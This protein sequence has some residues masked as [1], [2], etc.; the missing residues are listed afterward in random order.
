MHR[1]IETYIFHLS[2]PYEDIPIRSG[3]KLHSEDDVIS[4]AAAAAI[5]DIAVA[6]APTDRV[7]A[8]STSAYEPVDANL[9]PC[10]TCSRTF[11]RPALERHVKICEKV[12]TKKRNVFDPVKQRIEVRER[13]CVN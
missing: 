10:P 13:N 2:S 6:L 7:L 9:L 5:P 12:S 11:L 4:P 3:H 8:P 1:E